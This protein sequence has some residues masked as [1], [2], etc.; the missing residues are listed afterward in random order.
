MDH[1][2]L[3]DVLILLATAVV[4][5]VLSLRLRLT[6][7]FG[8][9]AVGMLMGPFGMAVISDTELTRAFAEFGVVFL[10][11][12]IG[13]EFSLPQLVRMK[14]AVLGLGGAQVLLT[15]LIATGAAIIAGLPVESAVILGGVISMSS[16]AM[17]TKML[18]DQVEL[19]HHHGR[20]SIGI[21]LFQDLMVIPFLI[22][23]AGLAGETRNTGTSAVFEAF[24]EGLLALAA[25]MALGRWVVKP[26][27]Q[28]LAR[29]RSRELFTFAI[30]LLIIGSAWITFRFGLSLGLGAFIAGMMLGETEF[31]HQIESEIRP[32]RD[33]L[34]GLFFITIGMLFNM[35][36]LPDILLWVVLLLAA[37]VALKLILITGLCRLWG[38][39]AMTSLRT[40]LILAHGG[41]FSFAIL[42]IAMDAHI[43]SLQLGQIILAAVLISMALAPLAIRYNGIIAAKLLPKASLLSIKSQQD[44]IANT[45]R[46]LS[47][48]VIICGYGRVGQN[49]ARILEGEGIPYLALD[50]DPLLVHNAVT[51]REP[52]TFGDAA[53][54]DL[55]KAARISSAAAL[56]ISVDDVKVALK[57]LGQVRQISRDLPILVRSPDDSNLDLLQSAGATEVIP[58]TLESSLMLSSHLLLILRIPVS[59]ILSKIQEIRRSRYELLRRLFPGEE[60]VVV[61]SLAGTEQ[62]RAIELSHGTWGIQK[63]VDELGLERLNVIVTA[64]LRHERRITHPPAGTLLQAG[65]TLVLFGAPAALDHVEKMLMQG[66]GTS[67]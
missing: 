25:I 13:L 30:L 62:L 60:R 29:F 8:Y 38:W 53:D 50:L 58:E 66:D 57:I 41:E 37:L 21:L 47:S 2:Y 43:F 54:L 61:E 59:R 3:T 52:V 39:N 19:R 26:L 24:G 20:N 9:L 27:L 16:T 33:V 48:H 64:L 65:D 11:F 5:T 46:G 12:T 31:R 56:V 32:F 63:R 44:Q 40:G 45:A 51:A 28:W 42:A 1:S 55:L 10:L 14:D 6:P 67:D 15:T 4:I 23:V 22:L 17:V 49:V 35:E 34:L 7:V 36:L 18:A